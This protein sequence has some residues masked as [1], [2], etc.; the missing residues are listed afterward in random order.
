VRSGQGTI[1]ELLVRLH[2]NASLKQLGVCGQKFNSLSKILQN[3]PSLLICYWVGNLAHLFRLAK[4]FIHLAWSGRR[5]IMRPSRKF[6]P[7]LFG[8]SPMGA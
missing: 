8:F 1:N 3:Y 5:E 2:D 4:F 6:A 7:C